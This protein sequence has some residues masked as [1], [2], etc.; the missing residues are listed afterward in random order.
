MYLI[1]AIGQASLR[2]AQDCVIRSLVGTRDD[3]RDGEKEKYLVG[4][5]RCVAP[6]WSEWNIVGN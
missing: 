4:T 6:F 2:N 3:E 5:P 1:L